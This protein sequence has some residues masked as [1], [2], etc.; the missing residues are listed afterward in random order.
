MAIYG[1]GA[2]YPPDDVSDDFVLRKIACIGWSEEE[3]SSLHQILRYIKIGDIIYIK[4]SPI[5]QGLRVKAVG[6]V[7][8]NEIEEY[9]L[10]MGVKVEW[11]WHG[12]EI[13]KDVVDKYNV[14]NNTIY[15]EFNRDI[16]DKIIDLMINK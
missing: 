6:L 10:G 8:D 15:E 11:L 16:Q 13:I 1:I 7:V 14:R 4:S 12:Q 2:Y 5:G 3:A 9:D